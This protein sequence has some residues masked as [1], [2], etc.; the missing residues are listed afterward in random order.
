LVDILNPIASIASCEIVVANLPRNL[1]SIAFSIVTLPP[2]DLVG[3][4]PGV[5]VICALIAIQVIYA[6]V[7]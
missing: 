1:C 2:M 6:P 5:Q 7:P 3:G 4:R